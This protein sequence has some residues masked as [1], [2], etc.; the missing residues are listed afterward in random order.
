MT[1]AVGAEPAEFSPTT[2]EDQRRS[3]FLLHEETMTRP[4]SLTFY[5]SMDEY[6]EHLGD[7]L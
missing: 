4:L 1:E 2:T 5:L 6:V 7:S 3:V